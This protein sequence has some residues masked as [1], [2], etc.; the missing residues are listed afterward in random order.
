MV[1]GERFDLDQDGSEW[2]SL[3]AAR[4]EAA[5]TLGQIAHDAMP[6]GDERTMVIRIRG[7]NNEALLMLSMVFTVRRLRG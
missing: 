3:E 1:D 5:R 4:K 2:E 7:E 6:D